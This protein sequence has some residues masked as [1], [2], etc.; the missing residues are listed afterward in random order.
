[1]GTFLPGRICHSAVANVSP[2]SHSHPVHTAQPTLSPRRLRL[3][4][5]SGDGVGPPTDLSF[6]SAILAVR[7]N[8]QRLCV[9]LERSAFIHNLADLTLLESLDTCPNPTGVCALS[10]G[11]ERCHLAIPASSTSG[12]VLVHDALNLHTL[13][14]VSSQAPSHPHPH[15]HLIPPSPC[16]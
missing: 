1:M 12:A 2:Q 4:N 6:V 9:L 10:L 15:P 5:T 14:Q 3:L 13:C 7:M 8:R 11:P 16:T